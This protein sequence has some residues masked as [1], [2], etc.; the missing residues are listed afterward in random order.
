MRP[1]L[2]LNLTFISFFCLYIALLVN[3][4]VLQ[5]RQGSFFKLRAQNQYTTLITTLLPRAEVVDRNG[6]PIALNISR[7]S[8][9]IIPS[10]LSQPDK[11]RAFLGQHFPAALKRFDKKAL[12]SQK[13]TQP[14][15]FY[16]QRHLSDDEVRLIKESNLCDIHV[17]KEPHRFY[18]IASTGPILGMTD[19]DNKGLM[20]IEKAYDHVL[21]GDPAVYALEQE[22]RS[23]HYYFNKTAQADGS[24]GTPIGLTLDATLQFLAYEETR[25]AVNLLN[26]HEG[27][28][29]I[30]DP[31]NGDILAMAQYP[32]FDPN[33]R[34]ITDLEK[35]KNK[36]VTDAYELGSVIKVFLALAAI[37]EAVVCPEEM[38]DCENTMS[39][40]IDGFKVNTLKPHGLLT[41]SRVIELSNNIGTSKIAPRLG[42]RIYQHYKRCGFGSK[43]GLNFAGEQRGFVNHPTKWSKLSKF[44]LS[45][46]Y[47]IRATLLQLARA[48]SI[49]AN[50]GSLVTPRLL[51][52]APCQLSPRLYKAD[53]IETI[54]DMLRKTVTHGTAHRARINGYNVFGKTGTANLLIN[55]VYQPSHNIFTFVGL[56]EK[57]AYKRII[58]TFIKETDKKDA[59]AASTASLLF[60]KVAHKMLI[61][62]KII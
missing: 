22:G 42:A 16:I 53:T 31:T 18:P 46:G 58:V 33:S 19:I 38:I 44:S 40:Y 20:G 50:D 41:F 13:D 48:F 25:D 60:E 17:L 29:L 52:S 45:F 23:G 12:G 57:G 36:L 1:T 30:L 21:A 9:F 56:I 59:T 7:F 27:A 47:E 11:V 39:T 28:V 62:D 5:I 2:R 8:A 61:H 14:S 3:L 24:Q 49:V 34:V 43:T 26:A 37:E 35:T 10:R 51:L 32:N 15:F 6:R 4:Y 54:R 55:G